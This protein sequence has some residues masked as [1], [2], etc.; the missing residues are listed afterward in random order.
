MGDTNKTAKFKCRKCSM[1]LVK[2]QN[3]CIYCGE[4]VKKKREV[5]ECRFA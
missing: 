1:P 4:V 2:G 5:P 3:T